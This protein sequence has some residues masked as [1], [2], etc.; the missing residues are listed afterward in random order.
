[1]NRAAGM[2]NFVRPAFVLDARAEFDAAV[3]AHPEARFVDALIVDV[4]GILRGKRVPLSD[5]GRLYES[6]M[7]LPSSAYLMDPRGEMTTPFG[8]GIA[9]GD[10]DGTAWP[11]PGTIAPVWGDGPPRL[12]VLT[13]M[14]NEAG[15]AEPS[16]PRV[17]VER[18]LERF[19]ALGL[20]PVVALEL[21]FYLIDPKRREDGAPL[22]P[23]DPWTGTRDSANGVYEI[24]DLDRYAAFLAA[25]DDA[26][27]HQN[28]PLGAASSEYAPGQFEVNL[29]HRAEAARAA[30]DAIF[31]KHM[32]KAAARATGFDATFM[33]KPYA[34]KTGSGLHIHVSILDGAGRNIFDDGS[35]EGSAV[36]RHAIGGLA[37][38][39][40]ESMALFAPS[41][42]AYRRFQ[43]DMFAP[44]NRRWGYNNRFAGLRIPVSPGEARRVEH[45]ASGADANPYYALAA[46]LAGVHHGLTNKIEPALPAAGNLS[47]EPDMALPFTMEDALMKLA[48]AKFLPAYLGEDAV[49]L[50]RESKR[51]EL[52]RFRR[53]VSPAEY[54]WYL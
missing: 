21:E 28:I 49:S 45:R 27:A 8:R 31:L 26:A 29:R 46:V 25:L 15:E 24:R 19:A 44:V 5:A 42:N 9:D 16:D 33:A 50:Y 34:D 11:V 36:L 20:T 22:P 10:P 40:P 35:A 30:D 47:R 2:P 41:V 53:I 17:S 4:N 37:D 52:A 32:V 23:R 14:R 43:P 51:A 38:L 7:Q 12:Q 48:G 39:M 54:E 6:G 3:A 13:T 18:V 1:M